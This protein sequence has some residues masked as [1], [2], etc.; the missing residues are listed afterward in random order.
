MTNEERQA[1]FDPLAVPDDP[2]FSCDPNPT[3][4][5]DLEVV[6][7]EGGIAVRLT[8]G[9]S[10]DAKRAWLEKLKKRTKAGRA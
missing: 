4:V 5:Y 8:P 7:C 2:S 1:T 10:L 6:E 9:G 3:A